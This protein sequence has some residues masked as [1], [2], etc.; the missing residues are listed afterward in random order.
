MKLVRHTAFNLLGLGLPLLVAILAIPALL[1]GLGAERFGLLTLIWALAGYLSLFDLGLGRALTHGMSRALGARDVGQDLVDLK[2]WT[3][4]AASLLL[5]LGA[6]ATASMVL[7]SPWAV[8]QIAGVTEPN[9][10]VQ[11]CW[12]MAAALP[13][14]LLTAGL[15]GALEA[16][17]AF[18]AINLIRVP[19][20]LWTFLGPWMA[21]HFVG[22]DL[23]AMAQVLVLGRWSGC[24]VHAWVLHRLKPEASFVPRWRPAQARALLSSGGWMTVSNVVSPFMGYVDR[25]L[26]GAWV[27]ASAVSPYAIAQEVV[28]KLWILP[29]ALTAVLFPAFSSAGQDRDAVRR[30][31]MFGDALRLLLVGALPLAGL[32]A[33]FAGEV[34]QGWLGSQAAEQTA[35]LLQILAVG[36]FVNCLAHIPFNLLQGVGQ[37]RATAL[38]HVIELPLFIFALALLIPTWGALGAAWAWLGR[39]LFDTSALFLICAIQQRWPL[40]LRWTRDRTLQFVAVLITFSALAIESIAGRCLLLLLGLVLVTVP[41]RD[42]L[43]HGKRSVPPA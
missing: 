2:A 16:L 28:G 43:F 20:G 24:V 9:Q 10:V 38:L 18:G 40:R 33:A 32:M 41:C 4:T 3:G 25:F 34:L 19:L 29:G 6:V 1:Q 14:V 7:L 5:G 26:I 37:A 39:M 11:A 15:R 31:R 21:L 36:G 30:R 13:A 17:Q 23:A 27:S 22:P 42:L 35:V 12:W 8:A